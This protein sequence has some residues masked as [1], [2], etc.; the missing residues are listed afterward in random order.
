MKVRKARSEEI[1]QIAD[2]QQGLMFREKKIDPTYFDLSKHAKEGF[3]EFAKKKIENRKS[4]LL[5]A[6]IDD[7][8]VGYILGWIKERPPVFRLKKIG[9]ISDCFVVKKFRR[10][11]IGEKLTQ[12]MLTWFKTKRL[13]HVELVVT[14]KNK[15]GLTAWKNLGFEEYRKIM[16]RKI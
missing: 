9:Y 11:G 15:L 3:V 1:G 4:R 8:I 6:I 13:N 7:K 16:Q 2:L 14:S 12:K 5:V 10:K